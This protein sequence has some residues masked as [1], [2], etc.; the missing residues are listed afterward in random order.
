MRREG[1]V[2][3]ELDIVG[4]IIHSR[5]ICWIA[6]VPLLESGVV[7]VLD[8]AFTVVEAHDFGSEQD[9]LGG[10]SYYGYILQAKNTKTT[11]ERQ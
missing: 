1:D 6:S 4:C 8:E 5:C 3:G 9:I 7:V 2:G 10:I 11:P